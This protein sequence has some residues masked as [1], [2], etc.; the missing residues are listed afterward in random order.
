MVQKKLENF[1]KKILPVNR[2]LHRKICSGTGL[3]LDYTSNRE[4]MGILSAIFIDREYADYFPMQ[5]EATVVDVGCH[6]GYFSFFAAL[7]LAP[8]ARILALE[9]SPANFATLQ[10]NLGQ[11]SFHNIEAFSIGLDATSGERTF[12]GGTSYNH[13]F[14]SGAKKNPTTITTRSLK[15]FMTAEKV[16][17]IDFLKLDCEGAEYPILLNADK[18]TLDKI[19]TLSLEFHDLPTEGYHSLQI[20]RHL[21]AH[22]FEIVKY[23]HDPD[24]SFSNLS[25]GKII[26]TK[27]H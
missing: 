3:S 18:E 21:K 15:D 20:I 5:Q 8:Q 7:N 1:L 11:N 17:H 26:A 13:S 22:G 19:T 14:F 12:Y 23:H 2:Y 27:F 16:Q 10:K 25:F 24:Y 9:P 4:G 6:F